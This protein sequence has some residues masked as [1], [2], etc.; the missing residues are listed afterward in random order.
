[1]ALKSPELRF[2][3]F[4]IVSQAAPKSI[5]IESLKRS[6]LKSV[7]SDPPGRISEPLSVTV[8]GNVALNVLAVATCAVISCVE[9]PRADMSSA[10][11]MFPA[12]SP[13]GFWNCKSISAS[14]VKAP[15]AIATSTML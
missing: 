5:E 13:S 15:P 4:E 14:T 6:A 8:I 9:P 12:A 1:M 11:V 3:K 7:I 10:A 2:S